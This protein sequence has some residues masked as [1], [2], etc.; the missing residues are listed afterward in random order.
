MVIRQRLARLLQP[1]RQTFFL[2]GPR[3]TG[4]STWVRQHFAKATRFDLL[5]EA[6]YQELLARPSG[7]ADRIRELPARS[8]VCVDEVQRLP[9]LLNEVHR[10]VED[11][12]LR[13]VLLGSSARKLRRAGVNLLGGRGLRKALYPFLPTELEGR[14]ELEPALRYGTLPVVMA[15]EQPEQTLDAYVLSYLKEEIHAE[16]IVRNLPGFSRFLPVAALFH[17]QTLNISGLARDAGV[18][19]TTVDDYVSILEDTLL[20][21]RLPGFEARLRARER[22]HP[23][24]Y[25]IDPGIVRT[26][27]R[28]LGPVTVEER[29]ALFEG[30]V[31][32]L[33]RA[34]NDYR[35][36]YDELTYWSPASTAAGEIDFLLRRGSRFIA[37][38]VK[39]GPK[40][41]SDDL[42]GF[43]AIEGLKGLERKIL[44]YPHAPRLKTATGVDVLSLADF[45]SAL[46]RGL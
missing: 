39:S 11:R 29:G 2:F 21:W 35:G 14:F 45:V 17:A 18:S 9:Q 37:V 19:R 5:D 7:F 12:G 46:E 23:K 22:K 44:V 8:W 38:E 27:K 3:G 10:F 40:L 16:A 33:L 1:P 4:K 28:Q 25:W 43:A 26:L 41:R 13:F 30:F 24:L 20:A 36:L 6:L 31:A 15:S 42:Q 34:W 32:M